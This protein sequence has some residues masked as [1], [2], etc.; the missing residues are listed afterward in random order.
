MS[1]HICDALVITCI[2]FR[3]QRSINKW[4][5]ANFGDY[6]YDRVALGGGV[7]DFYTILKQV[8]IS[9]RL[10]K[11]KKV[12]LMNHEDCGAYGD[13]GTFE[14]HKTDLEQEEVIIEKLYPHLD[15]ET[16]YIHLN[17]TFDEISKTSPR[18]TA[19]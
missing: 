13:L 1:A 16:Y 14:R 3:F 15:V 9:N 18:G 5:K 17:G 12:L 11:I 2:D 6:V 19:H 8:E 10:H 7:F 4:L